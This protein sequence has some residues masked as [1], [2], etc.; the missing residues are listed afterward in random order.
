MLLYLFTFFFFFFFFNDTATTEIYTLSLPDALPIFRLAPGLLNGWHNA[1]TS[2][3]VTCSRDSKY[4]WITPCR[5]PEE[6]P[7]PQAENVLTISVD[8][9]YASMPR[10]CANSCACSA[11]SRSAAASASSVATASATP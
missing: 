9:P 7:S 5:Q 10:P 3:C 2:G 4:A 11:T 1:S 8:L 6:K